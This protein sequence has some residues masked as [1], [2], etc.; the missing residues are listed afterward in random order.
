MVKHQIKIL[1]HLPE[2]GVII[3]SVNG[4]EQVFRAVGLEHIN[5]I[6]A[7]ADFI[8]QVEREAYDITV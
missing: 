5:S 6:R 1:D 3:I 8:K 7:Q 4:I 2:I